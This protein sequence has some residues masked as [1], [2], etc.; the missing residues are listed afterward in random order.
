LK[1]GTEAQKQ[2]YLPQMAKG[3]MITSIGMTEPNCGSDLK[4]LEPLPKIKAT[5][6]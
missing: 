1:Y 4:A 2:K 5:I 3:E 6:I